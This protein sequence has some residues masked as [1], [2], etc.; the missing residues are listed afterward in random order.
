MVLQEICIKKTKHL[1]NIRAIE[2]CNSKLI[3]S[4]G[5]LLVMI[6][7]ASF[8]E[9]EILFSVHVIHNLFLDVLNLQRLV[10]T[11]S[12]YILKETFQQ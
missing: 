10:S 1:S 4:V 8:T 12:S 2:N 11:R 6:S 3:Q 7:R 5:V 9:A